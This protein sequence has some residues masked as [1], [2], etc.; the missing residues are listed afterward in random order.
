MAAIVYSSHV[1]SA[2]DLMK[3]GSRLGKEITG[4]TADLMAQPKT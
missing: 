4:K 3:K 2:E 1:G